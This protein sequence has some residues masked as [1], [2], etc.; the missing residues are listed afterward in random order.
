MIPVVDHSPEGK[1]YNIALTK[2]QVYD[3]EKDEVGQSWSYFYALMFFGS[4]SI[5]MAMTNS[6]DFSAPELYN[7]NQL[8]F[9]VKYTF[10]IVWTLFYCFILICP[11]TRVYKNYVNPMKKSRKDPD[12]GVMDKEF[13]GDPSTSE[14]ASSNT[15]ERSDDTS[16]DSESSEEIRAIKEKSKV[17]VTTVTSNTTDNYSYEDEIEEQVNQQK[18][19]CF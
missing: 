3:D 11:C 4:I 5:M 9:F 19:G 6:T 12:E 1:D 15:E 18:C 2:L 8:A 17:T 13:E 10:S 14:G 7:T 16:E